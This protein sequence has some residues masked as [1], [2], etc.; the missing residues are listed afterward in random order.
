MTDIL[1]DA[2]PHTEKSCYFRVQKLKKLA[3]FLELVVSGLHASSSMCAKHRLASSRYWK[4]NMELERFYP[5]RYSGQSHWAVEVPV[6]AYVLKEAFQAECTF[7]AL[8]ANTCHRSGFNCRA[9]IGLCHFSVLCWQRFEWHCGE[10]VTVIEAT[11]W[12]ILKNY[13]RFALPAAGVYALVVSR[14]AYCKCELQTN[15]KTYFQDVS[16]TCLRIRSSNVC[17][18]FF[19]PIH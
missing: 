8:F 12:K 9:K 14:R 10:L 18:V 19:I 4:S 1:I 3:I 6:P 13:M 11:K 17:F 5:I 16:R 2:H 7:H 15:Y